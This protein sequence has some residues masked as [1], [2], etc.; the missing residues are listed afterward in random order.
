MFNNMNNESREYFCSV[1]AKS[2]E[3]VMT[4]GVSSRW[5]ETS[6]TE[7]KCGEW[8]SLT[9]EKHQLGR[10]CNQP[11]SKVRIRTGSDLITTEVDTRCNIR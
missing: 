5:E 7:F 8:V 10:G 2:H 4:T 1:C 6:Q 3:C 9:G 11:A